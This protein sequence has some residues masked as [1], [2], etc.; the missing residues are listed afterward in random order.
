MPVLVG[1]S[2]VIEDGL[3]CRACDK[4]FDFNIDDDA[5]GVIFF[6]S[7]VLLEYP[8]LVLRYIDS[9]DV[10]VC[11]TQRPPWKHGPRVRAR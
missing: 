5:V 8:G 4:R 10:L 9:R 1:Q 11:L 2:L 6:A 3:Y 7:D